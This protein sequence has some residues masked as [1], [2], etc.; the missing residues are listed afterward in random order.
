MKARHAV[1]LVL[2]VGCVATGCAVLR[3]SPP[4]LTAQE[5]QQIRG[6]LGEFAAAVRAKYPEAMQR[7]LPPNTSGNRSAELVFRFE[8]ACWLG[9]YSGYTVNME[10]ALSPRN[11]SQA[12][13]ARIKLRLPG[14]NV[15]GQSLRDTVVL[16]RSGEQWWL[17]DFTME[18]PEED[19]RLD[20]PSEVQASLRAAVLPVLRDLMEGHAGDV[21]YALPDEPGAHHRRA[22]AGFFARL[23][24]AP[25]TVSVFSDL[26]IIVQLDVLAW[27]DPSQPLEVLY[28]SP[29]VISIHYEVPYSWASGRAGEPEMLGLDFIFVKRR[30]GWSFTRFRGSGEALPYS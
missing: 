17:H 15:R 21:Y 30:G 6:L 24:G 2:T 26:R 9:R 25:E 27:P 16:A 14:S 8:Q 13:G 18:L 11:M 20:P 5:S 10:A 4:E 29:G 7:L 22:E 3:G 28:K 19:D 23:F 12:K 1:A